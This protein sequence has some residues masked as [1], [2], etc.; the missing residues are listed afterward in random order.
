MGFCASCEFALGGDIR[1]CGS[2]M[3]PESPIWCADKLGDRAWQVVVAVVLGLGL[4]IWGFYRP[5]GPTSK[6]A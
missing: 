2:V 1:E 6:G 5:S 4:T 3:A